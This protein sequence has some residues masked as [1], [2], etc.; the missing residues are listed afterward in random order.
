MDVHLRPFYLTHL[1]HFIPFPESE[2]SDCGEDVRVSSI[3]NS[4]HADSVQSAGSGSELNIVA[5]PVENF[6]TSKDCEVL[7]FGLSDSGAIV[8][9]DHQLAGAGSELL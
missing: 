6:G 2:E 3:L 7:K 4:E 5:V 8:C 1:L 9:D